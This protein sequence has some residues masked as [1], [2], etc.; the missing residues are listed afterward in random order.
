VGGGVMKRAGFE[1]V[2]NEVR[3]VMNSYMALPEIAPP[4]LGGNAGVLGAMAL[5]RK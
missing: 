2:R 1:P 4:E 5:A 3:R